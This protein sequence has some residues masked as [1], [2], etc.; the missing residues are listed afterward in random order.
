VLACVVSASLLHAHRS[1][2]PA[3]SF[4]RVWH[5]YVDTTI[6]RVC[7]ALRWSEAGRALA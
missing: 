6:V 5:L 2:D 4:A 3:I 7:E 1:S